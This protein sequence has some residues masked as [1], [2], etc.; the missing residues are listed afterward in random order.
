MNCEIEPELGVRFAKD[1]G[2]SY[3][4]TATELIA[5]CPLC[6][7]ADHF[8][9]N[10]EN[11]LFSCKVCGEEGN[12]STLHKLLGDPIPGLVEMN[13][14]KKPGELPNIEECHSRLM[15]S[16]DS[17]DY[18]VSTR[19]WKIETIEKMR[20]GLFVTSK[21]KYIVYP[22]VNG[23]KY[24]YAKL[25]CIPPVPEGIEKFLGA[26]GRENPLFN[27]DAMNLSGDDL[28]F[29]EGEGDCLAL[30]STGIYNVCGVPGANM[31]KAV[32]IDRID[33]WWEK[34]IQAGKKPHIYILYDA[35]SVGQKAAE[36]ISKRIGIERCWNI[37][38]PL[39]TKVDGNGIGKDANEWV[40]SFLVG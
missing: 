32:W 34:R 40:R 6:S 26:K 28:I 20:I 39:F 15:A 9:M 17:M 5:T 11:G 8:Y 38:L 2:W 16:E 4:T 30:L 36:E 19:G 25:R 22:Y 37:K 3:K 12:I 31:K 29:V 18:L 14:P 33:C 13:S 1:H 27:A 10:K 21:A 35:D 24:L 23:G 7:K